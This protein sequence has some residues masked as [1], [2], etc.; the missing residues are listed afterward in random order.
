M[1]AAAKKQKVTLDGET[2]TLEQVVAVSRY[3]AEADLHPTAKEKVLR[4]REYVDHLIA[5]N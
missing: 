1:I 4:S 2:L 3:G 5:G